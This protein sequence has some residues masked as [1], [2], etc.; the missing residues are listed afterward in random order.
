MPTVP[1]RRR[2]SSAAVRVQAALAPPLP[3]ALSCPPNFVAM[4]TSSR[5]LPSALPRN[6][7]ERVLPYMSAG[8]KTVIPASSAAWTTA[9]LSSSSFRV[10]KLLQPSPTNDTVR[11]PILRV[12]M[13][14]TLG[15]STLVPFSRCGPASPETNLACVIGSGVRGCS[16]GFGPL[17]V[18]GL[19]VPLREERRLDG[20]LQGAQ[21]V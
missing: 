18:R 4:T 12:S 20:V 9:L 10:P 14:G 2:L 6:C 5:R 16:A 15:D 7:S 8:S 21:Q 19:G 3:S 17:G 1:S 11:L 13:R